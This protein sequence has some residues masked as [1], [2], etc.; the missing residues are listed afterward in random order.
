MPDT[1]V[2]VSEPDVTKGMSTLVA[3]V[4]RSLVDQPESVSVSTVANH[5]ETNLQVRVA[6]CDLGKVIGKQGRTARALRTI[7]AAASMKLH[8]R[9]SLEIVEV[10]R[11]APLDRVL[12]PT[13]D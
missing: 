1:T 11:D 13:L 12:C 9:F 8:H 10:D 2:A 7:L 6:S 4:I 3:D 5:T